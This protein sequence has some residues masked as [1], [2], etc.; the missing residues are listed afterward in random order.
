MSTEP[1]LAAAAVFIAVMLLGRILAS[2]RGRAAASAG[3]AAPPPPQTLQ[4]RLAAAGIASRGGVAAFAA[5]QGLACVAG[6]WIGTEM[7]SSIGPD[8]INAAIGAFLGVMLAAF[9]GSSWLASRRERRRLE[10]AAEFP[11]MLDLLRVCLQGS[12]GLPAAWAAV[13]SALD[14]DSDALAKEMGRIDLEVGFG[15]RWSD[16]LRAAGDRTGVAEF[17]SLGSMLEQTARFGAEL[18]AAVGGL[19][20]SLRHSEIQT[21]EERAHRASVKMLVP[22]AVLMLPASILLIAGPMV[23]MLL[24][25]LQGDGT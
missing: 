17:R 10:I 19:A 8:P 15:G 2:R 12:M 13:R 7:A 3:E 6:A 4:D 1:L 23:M 24:K 25:A 22:L 14:A 5:V 11:L 18:S 9:L 20:E 21:L 16:S